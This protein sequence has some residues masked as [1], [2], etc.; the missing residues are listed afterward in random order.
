VVAG[1]EY[2]AECGHSHR[3]QLTNPVREQAGQPP[4][5]ASWSRSENKEY[6]AVVVGAGPNGL[7][8]AITLAQAGLSVLLIEASNTIGGGSRSLE[9]TLPGFI[10][11]PCATIHSL[12]V[13]SPFFNQLPLKQYGLEWIFPSASLAHPLA[14]GT[15]VM[16]ERSVVETSRQL[17]QDAGAYR[18][19][20]NPFVERWPS[21][22][23]E[24]L[25][26]LRIP[27]D[28]FIL[29]RF[30]LYAIRSASSLAKSIFREERARALFAGL[31]AHSIQSLK[32]P[33]TAAFG[34]VLGISGHAA[35]WPVARGGS[36]VIAD[37]LGGYFKSLGG[38]IV[39]NCPVQSFED[40]PA[41]HLLL[42]D[43]TPRQLLRIAGE[44]LPAAYRRQLEGYRYGPGVFKVDYALS[45]PAPWTAPECAR[46]ATVHIGGGPDEIIATEQEVWE[47]R[48]PQRP[49]VLFA[50]QTLI[51]PGRAPEGKHTAWAY[52]HVPNGSTTDMSERIEA[53]IE[54]FEP[55]FRDCV[56]D[57]HVMPPQQIEQYN[58]NYIG[59]D[60]N[61]G[62]QDLWQLF[63]RPTI[64]WVP[65]STPLK[66]VYL[67][68]SS[69]PPG[70]GVHGMCGFHA[71]RAALRSISHRVSG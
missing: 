70:G 57:R 64:Q 66:G 26:P 36:Q 56:L 22:A 60:I 54:R 14:D 17:G 48:H 68:S 41:S 69:T 67:C 12:G 51:D 1:E 59:G 3:A 28:P 11:D 7:A 49:F 23:G 25:G 20:M 21:L 33:P 13:T 46:A 38:K 65:Y 52:C 40:I 43:I 4:M 58:A 34:L 47:G 37:A 10:H 24:I 9:L 45:A 16:L 29:A 5:T 44:R 53:Q 18:K 63:T 19:F 62:V 2:L 30:G 35:G 8:A 39:T 50:Q 31:A 55:G 27:R 32:R 71:A 15:A 6:E 42:L 61:G